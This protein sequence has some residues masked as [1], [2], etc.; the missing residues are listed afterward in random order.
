MVRRRIRRLGP[1]QRRLHQGRAIHF[2]KPLPIR[3]RPQALSRRSSIRLPKF[4]A[5]AS[6][7]IWV[8]HAS[9]WAARPGPVNPTTAKRIAVLMIG[10]QSYDFQFVD[11]LRADAKA[12]CVTLRNMGVGLAIL[13]GDRAGNVAAA[14]DGTTILDFHA[15]LEPSDK[16][17]ILQDWAN[18]GRRV[19]MVGDGLNDAPALAAAHASMSLSSASDIARSAAGV[20]F[21]GSSL[22]PVASAVK[23]ARAARAAGN[24]EFRDCCGLQ[25]QSRSHWR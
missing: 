19:L 14:A 4:Q 12:T 10:N 7:V 6:R 25:T 21:T 22:G 24:R 8:A 16:L 23:I 18:Q 9:A 20:V 15:A 5:L 2:R 13:S 11:R 17:R 1:L 3:P